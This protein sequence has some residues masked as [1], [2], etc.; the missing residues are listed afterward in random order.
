MAAAKRI[1][2]FAAPA[3]LVS[4][5][6]LAW[7]QTSS[8]RDTETLWEHAL[9]VAP[10]NGV[11]HYNLAALAMDRGGID[12]AISHY[13]RAIAGGGNQEI[14]SQL[15]PALLHNNLGVALARKRLEL[16][17]IEQFRKAIELR[18]DFADAHTNLGTA[19]LA[20]GDMTGAI[21]QFRK[22]VSVPPEDAQSHFRLAVALERSGE[23][24]EALKEYRRALELTKDPELS[25]KLRTAI[26]RQ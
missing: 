3:A 23:R 9:A 14:A 6:W 21:A 1:W 25:R 11:A 16:E 2:G 13:E 18:D 17:A 7:R 5:A 4:L 8:W 20:K 19:L 12:D 15:S 10:H 22:A 24:A 26:G